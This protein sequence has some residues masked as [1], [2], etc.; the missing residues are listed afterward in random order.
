MQCATTGHSDSGDLGLC[1]LIGPAAG[2]SSSSEYRLFDDLE[3][4]PRHFLDT[5]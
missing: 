4:L 3:A 2:G 5:S 1:D